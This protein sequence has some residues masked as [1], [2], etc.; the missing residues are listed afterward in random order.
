MMIMVKQRGTDE[1]TRRVVRAK[2]K[3]RAKTADNV[4]SLHDARKARAKTR[5]DLSLGERL[6]KAREAAGITQEVLAKQV[7]HLLELD[8]VTDEERAK[9]RGRS[10][11]AQWETGRAFPEFTTISAIARAVKKTPEYLAYGITNEPKT[12]M[13]EPEVMGFVLAPEIQ[14]LDERKHKEVQKW[15]LPLDWL[16]GELG[17]TSYKDLAIYKV[18]VNGDPFEYGDRVIIDRNNFRPSPPG[19]FLYWDGV[20]A[21]IAKMRVVPSAGK[22]H[23]V[24]V[25]SSNGDFEVDVDK[26]SILGRVKGVWKKA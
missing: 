7:T 11:I 16:R 2:T 26:L 19:Y 25:S 6:R 5:I 17:V 3:P 22:K 8:G 21:N 24:K 20:G 18:E 9:K 12:V 4:T 23:I 1:N 15:G 13:P 14:I 10:S